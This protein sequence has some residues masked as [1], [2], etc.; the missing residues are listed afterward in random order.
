[1]IG[2]TDCAGSS[3]NPKL[4]VTIPSNCDTLAAP[5]APPAVDGKADA[6]DVA[7]SVGAWG[8]RNADRLEKYAACEKRMRDGYAAAK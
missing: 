1:M 2:L 6:G 5:L 3:G 4:A 8:K 7:A